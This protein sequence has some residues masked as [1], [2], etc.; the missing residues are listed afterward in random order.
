MGGARPALA[1]GEKRGER[2][3][4]VFDASLVVQKMQGGQ[5]P[6]GNWQESGQC[7]GEKKPRPPGWV[8]KGGAGLRG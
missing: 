3:L 7:W 2:D 5:K 1:G 4:V 8:L 6:C